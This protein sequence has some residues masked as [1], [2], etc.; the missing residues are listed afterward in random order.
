M[1]AAKLNKF[2]ASGVIVISF[3]LPLIGFFLEYWLLGT[4][5]AFGNF[6]KWFI[7]FAAGWRLFLAGLKQSVDPAFTAKE[8]FHIESQDCQPIV[9]ELGFA[10]ICMGLV[11]VIS[12]FIPSWRFV[13]AFI[14][15]IFFGIAGLQHLI[16]KPVSAN[17]NLALWTDLA[18]SAVLLSYLL[19]S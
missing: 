16:K 17:E 18:V 8:I 7:F 14:G 9:R 11:G 6:G 1:S 13:S 12:F 2:Y 4:E 19:V 3:I 10:N 15:C 5:L